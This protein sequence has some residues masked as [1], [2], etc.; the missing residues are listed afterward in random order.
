LHC[1]HETRLLSPK[2]QHETT[3][4]LTCKSLELHTYQTN[5]NSQYEP[6]YGSSRTTT[7][8]A[9]GS[10]LDQEPLSPSPS[11]D[12]SKGNSSPTPAH[13]E[14]G[15]AHSSAIVSSSR[16]KRRREQLPIGSVPENISA[17][18]SSD[19]H[20]AVKRETVAAGGGGSRTNDIR[21]SNRSKNRCRVATAATASAAAAAA[22]AAAMQWQTGE[23][24]DLLEA[25]A[26]DKPL[27]VSHAAMYPSTASDTV[28]D[29]R[30]TTATSAPLHQDLRPQLSSFHN[31][32]HNHQ[33]TRIQDHRRPHHVI[34]RQQQNRDNHQVH[35]QYH[36]QQHHDLPVSSASIHRMPSGTAAEHPTTDMLHYDHH[37]VF[38]MDKEAEF[39]WCGGG[40]GD[41]GRGGQQHHHHYLSPNL[42]P[43]QSGSNASN[44]D[45]RIPPPS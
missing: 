23:I 21:A 1:S 29:N 16:R 12:S 15:G 43:V 28:G 44:L 39:H 41:V 19:H 38:E 7:P 9:L 37:T 5:Q 6:V 42:D 10:P 25:T 40:M 26:E 8:S 13:I 22:A 18:S 33:D 27:A 11:S 31:H 3:Q 35:S 30:A 4:A 36:H 17:S 32:H 2:L 20:V 34:V 14:F 45:S 24:E